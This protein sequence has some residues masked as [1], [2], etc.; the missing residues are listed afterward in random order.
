MNEMKY[1][2]IFASIVRYTSIW[3]LLA[4]VVIHELELE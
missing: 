3:I 1:N 2:E 4:I